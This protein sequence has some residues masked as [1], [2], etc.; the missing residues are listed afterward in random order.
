MCGARPVFVDI[1]EDDLG[2]NP[3]LIERMISPKVKAIIALHYTG[4]PCK[5]DKILAIGK[6]RGI[7]VI[8]DAAH[9][10]GTRFKGRM[11]GSY[12]DLTCFSFDAIKT[13]TCIDGGAVV[14]RDIAE[15]EKLYPA[16]L[17][18]M[19]QSNECLYSNTRAFHY[20]VYTQGFRYHLANLHAS[21][22][23]SQ[24]SKLPEFIGNRLCY[25]RLYNQ[26]LSDV[27]GI[28][29]PRI[30]FDDASI[31]NYVIRV[32]DGKRAK[33]ADYLKEQDIGSGIHWVLGSW[34]T[35]LKSCRGADMIPVSNKIGA[36]IMTLPLWSYMSEKDIVTVVNAIRCFFGKCSVK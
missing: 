23:L 5:I 9:A 17:L 36:E 24:L 3:D 25:C 20:D 19:T 29:T 30:D 2:I 16:R 31:F 11:V 10:T 15:A 21:I 22:G 4:V 35:W 32:L 34:L 33:L 1:C 18:G 27:P 12:G 8:E 13:L 14:T 7:R 6:K 26:F 28:I